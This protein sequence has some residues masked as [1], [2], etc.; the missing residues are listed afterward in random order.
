MATLTSA[1]RTGSDVKYL[2]SGPP[3]FE[4]IAGS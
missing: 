3:Q 1:R 4:A 2:P